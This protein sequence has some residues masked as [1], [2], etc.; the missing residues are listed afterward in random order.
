MTAGEML[1]KFK[2]YKQQH[3]KRRKTSSGPIPRSGLSTTC[4]SFNPDPPQADAT[5]PLS[6]KR[7]SLIAGNWV[8]PTRE[9]PGEESV[10]I[11]NLKR[12]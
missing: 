10:K 2:I 1:F 8:K 11:N 9:W 3:L 7:R 12:K 5:I 4:H 6:R